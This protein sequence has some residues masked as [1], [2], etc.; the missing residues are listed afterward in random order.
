MVLI[1]ES[2]GAYL[3]LGTAIRARDKNLR[4]PACVALYSVLVQLDGNPERRRNDKTDMSLS[5]DMID[6][7]S[8]LVCPDET[9]RESAE[10]SPIYADMKGLPPM[11]VAY[12]DG[13]V[14]AY[15][16]EK[17]ID[18]LKASGVE[19]SAKAYSGAFH[20]F[21]A[22]GK[23]FPESAEVLENTIRFITKHI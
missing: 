12:D 9:M 16:S 17:L 23:M 21:P 11:I 13:E 4:L 2:G 8:A 19:V 15:D 18:K 7:I 20:A 22:M 10:V 3:S 1:G 14:L 5:A 6:V